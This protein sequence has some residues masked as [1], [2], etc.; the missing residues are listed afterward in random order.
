M[1]TYHS[2]IS[3][4]PPPQPAALANEGSSTSTSAPIGP[5]SPN[6]FLSM[7]CT[8]YVVVPFWDAASR[9]ILPRCHCHCHANQASTPIRFGGFRSRR[10]ISVAWAGP[11]WQW[12]RCRLQSEKISR[13]RSLPRPP[14]TTRSPAGWRTHT[15]FCDVVP[16]SHCTMH[17]YDEGLFGF[18]P[19]AN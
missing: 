8:Y 2:H 14:R 19:W 11:I 15:P 10:D 13:A 7:Y 16:A 17:Y 6:G 12:C 5:L 18:P 9:Q 1:C 4:R 3:R